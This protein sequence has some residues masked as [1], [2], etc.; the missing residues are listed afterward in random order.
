M[1]TAGDENGGKESQH[2]AAMYE[3]AL[4]ETLVHPN[5]VMIYSSVMQ[6]MNHVIVSHK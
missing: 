4:H 3:A 6:P 2:I 5:V 1:S